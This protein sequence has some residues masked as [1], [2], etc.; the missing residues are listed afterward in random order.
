VRPLVLGVDGCRSGWVGVVAGEPPVVVHADATIEGL[1][2][3]V[4][5]RYG[6][7]AVVAIDIPIG[8]PDHGRRAADTLAV[9]D[10]GR[11]RSSLFL[12]PIRAALHADDLATANVISRERTGTGVSAQAFALRKKVLEVDRWV[13]AAPTRVVEVHPELSFAT[14]AGWPPEFGKRTP[15]GRADRLARL[16][17]AGLDVAHLLAARPRGVAADDLLDAAAA[18]WSAARVADGTAECRPDPPECFSDGWPAAI[19]T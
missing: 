8:L 1:V 16:R 2:A 9:A 5:T 13:R 15:D 14:M 7:P 3:H 4:V 17:A 11:R 6:R 18:A 12:T 19:W 10:L